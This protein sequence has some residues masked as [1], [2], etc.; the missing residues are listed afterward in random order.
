VNGCHDGP[1]GM[2]G[3]LI[4]AA[5]PQDTIRLNGSDATYIGGSIVELAA[6]QTSKGSVG[7]SIK[8]SSS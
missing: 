5:S 7:T 3:R 4:G 1:I 6:G 8:S 2:N